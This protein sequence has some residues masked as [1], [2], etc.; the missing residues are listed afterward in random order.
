M[1][2]LRCCCGD[3]WWLAQEEDVREYWSYCGEIESLDLMRFPDTGRFKGI[4]FITFA[5][6]RA[7]ALPLR[8]CRGPG[9][10]P[11]MRT[12]PRACAARG[13]RGR[14]AVRWGESGQH[15]DP[16]GTVQVCG[17]SAQAKA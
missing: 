16:G 14:A 6:V 11:L 10:S 15:A 5:T 17:G 9:C 3:E 1:S 2:R 4:A 12:S 7:A 13:L 8:P